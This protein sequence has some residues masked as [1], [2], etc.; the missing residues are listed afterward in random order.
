MPRVTGLRELR[1]D[2]VAID[3][4]GRRWRVVP[5]GVVVRA[6]IAVGHELDRPRLRSLRRELKHAEALAAGARALRARELTTRRLRERLD[7]RA[8]PAAARDAAIETL[9]AAG[10]VDDTRFADA[11]ARALAARG[12]GDAAIRYDLV[13]RHGVEAVLAE[14]A[15]GN[16][17]PEVARAEGVAAAFGGR[18][19]AARALARR[20][21]GHEAVEA[22]VGVDVAEEPGDELG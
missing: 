1:G 2:R 13:A 5:T 22:V 19:R 11:R 7:R 4:D 17:E 10:L 15:I 16:L 8:L 12:L 9:S 6:G 3:L 14:Q 18:T 20:G 21:F